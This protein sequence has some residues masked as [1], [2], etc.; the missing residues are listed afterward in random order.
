M[1]NV[2]SE[3]KSGLAAIA[4]DAGVF[5]IIAM[6][7]RNTL[8]K[9]F[10]AVGIEATLADMQMA[11]IEVARHLTPHASGILLDIEVGV[12]AVQG[13]NTLAPGCGLLIAAENPDRGD[14]NGEPRPSLKA[15]QD[16]KWVK[17]NRGDALKLLVMMHPG[18]PIGVGEPD[19][20]AGTLDLV[21]TVIQGCKEAGVPSVIENLI[22][23]L[24]SQGELTTQER[25]DLIVE[26]ALLLNELKPDL[27]KLEYPGSAA[28]CKR[29]AEGLDVPWAVLSA[30]VAFSEFE[31]VVQISCSEGGASGFIAGRSV[32]KEAIGMSGDVLTKF[33]TEV[34]IPRLEKLNAAVVGIAR[35]YYEVGK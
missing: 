28:G 35:P 11:K 3:T 9:M 23:A 21:R 30:G 18:R 19:L 6:D 2:K 15:N 17:S 27:L 5:S 16:G 34:A 26:S 31:K 20:T 32:W 12:G 1:S 14:F 8:K 33:L 10:K 22:Y 24:P 25:E 29:L 7:Q 13:A 4:N